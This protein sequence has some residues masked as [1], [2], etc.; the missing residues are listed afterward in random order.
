MCK[1]D[2]NL[3]NADFSKRFK[4]INFSKELYAVLRYILFYTKLLFYCLGN[5]LGTGEIAFMGMV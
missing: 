4:Q 5:D 3:D 2:I 1:Y